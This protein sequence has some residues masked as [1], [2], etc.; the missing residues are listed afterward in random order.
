MR[1]AAQLARVIADLDHPD[2]IAVLL[3]EQG[4]RAQLARLLL[5][6]VERVHVQVVDQDIVDLVLGVTQHRDR[7]RGLRGEVEAQ[8]ARGVLRTRLRRRLAQRTAQRPVYQVRRSVR[9]GQRPPTLD[10]DLGERGRA[11]RDLAGADLAAVHDEAGQRGLHV[12][13]RELAAGHPDRARVG[14]LAATLGVERGAVQDQV[15]LGARARR[16]HRHAVDQQAEDGRLA[17]DLVITG[18]GDRAGPLEHLR[19]RGDV[20]VAGLLLRRV[21]LGAFPLLG[22]EPAETVLVDVQ[23]LLGRHLQGQVDREAV[24]VV[25]LERLGAGQRGGVLA[26]DLLD[27][28]VEDRGAGAQGAGERRLFRV[29]DRVDVGGNAPQLGVQLAHRLQRDRGELGH[30][31]V[32]RRRGRAAAATVTAGQHAQVPDAAPDDAAQHV[33]AALVARQDAV[34]DQHHRAA[35]VVRDDPQ[36]HVGAV[37]AAVALLGEFGRPV[38]DLPGGVDLVEV[39]DALQDGCHPLEPHAGVDVPRRQQALDVEVV[40]GPDLAQLILHEDQVPD[41]EEAVLVGGRAAVA[42]VFGA[43]IVVDLRARAAR[44][45]HAHVPVVVGQAA[46]LD[47]LGRQSDLVPPDRVRLVVPVQDGGPQLALREAEP[48]VRLGLG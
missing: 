16:G 39:V 30:E 29:D 17:G 15:D 1:A 41:L 48:A 42:A 36:G 6:G 19:E 4:Q 44:P 31:A 33:A 7:H 32:A 24:G 8:P 27:R 12:A 5:G 37:V 2:L 22:H 43:A 26:A 46:V 13:D 45:G 18:E 23:A 34:P 38:E 28:R 14:Q 25:Q 9:P 20:G 47:P 3:P 35:H 11:H 21:P 10:V 40:L